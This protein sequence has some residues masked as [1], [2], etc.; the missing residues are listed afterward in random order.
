LQVRGSARLTSPC[1]PV[2]SPLTCP[3]DD[4]PPV[5]RRHHRPVIARVCVLAGL[6]IGSPCSSPRVFPRSA[7]SPVPRSPACA[8]IVRV[9]L[10]RHRRRR[11]RG[12]LTGWASLAG[13]APFTLFRMGLLQTLLTVGLLVAGV[14]GMEVRHGLP[15]GAGPR[16]R[17]PSCRGHAVDRRPMAGGLLTVLVVY[18][19]TPWDRPSAAACGRHRNGRSRFG[20]ARSHRRCRRPHHGPERVRRIVVAG[21]S[22]RS[23]AS[24]PSPCAAHRRHRVCLA[25]GTLLALASCAWRAGSRSAVSVPHSS[26]CCSTCRGSRTGRGPNSSSATLGDPGRDCSPWR[27]SRSGRPTSRCSPSRCLP[28][29][30]WRSPWSRRGVSPGPCA[31]VLVIVFGRFAVLGD[32]GDLPFDAR[33]RCPAQPVAFGVSVSAGRS[34]PG[35]NSTTCATPDSAGVSRSDPGDDRGRGGRD[36]RNPGGGRRSMEHSRH[37]PRPVD[38]RLARRPTGRR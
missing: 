22:R 36:P 26:G 31:A 5:A 11:H 14:A 30:S 8:R 38:E 29:S 17:V 16:R 7:S 24:P 23:P 10:E 19:A 15:V 33:G 34:S 9:R 21:S 6:L 37:D 28:P 1:A 35:S 3:E 12:E 27:R 4:G 13:F 32:R 25:L 2:T 20:G 18:A